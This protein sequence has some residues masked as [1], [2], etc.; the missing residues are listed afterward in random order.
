M[1]CIIAHLPPSSS[2]PSSSLPVCPSPPSAPSLRTKQVR[3]HT[4]LAEKTA[5]TIDNS[6]GHHGFWIFTVGNMLA[7]L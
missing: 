1:R 3:A 6:L 5:E 4:R 7:G 2:T